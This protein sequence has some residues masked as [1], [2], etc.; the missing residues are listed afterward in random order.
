M[1]FKAHVKWWLFIS[2]KVLQE[3]AAVLPQEERVAMLDIVQ[4]VS[5]EASRRLR[6]IS[7]PELTA[8][9]SPRQTYTPRYLYLCMQVSVY[10]FLWFF[11]LVLFVSWAEMFDKTFENSFLSDRG[12]LIYAEWFRN[13]IISTLLKEET[14]K[15]VP[16]WFFLLDVNFSR[17]RLINLL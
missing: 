6:R 7:C 13:D 10:S 11:V 4:R 12:L 16:I 14:R 2:I 1:F 5:R 15:I 8:S 3:A 17:Q 9:G